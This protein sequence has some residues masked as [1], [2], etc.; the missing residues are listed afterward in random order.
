[1]QTPLE[2]VKARSSEWEFR[3]LPVED[4]SAA[5]ACLI[6]QLGKPYDTFGVLG[7][8]FN[9]N[10]QDDRK[11]WCS[12]YTAMAALQGGYKGFSNVMSTITPQD[13]YNATEA[14]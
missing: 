3:E 6:A 9:R 8:G 5:I 4:Y 13:V 12:E 1:V 11:W 14:A 7:L 10:W 2:K